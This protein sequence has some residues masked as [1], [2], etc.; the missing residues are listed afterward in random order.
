VYNPPGHMVATANQRP[1]GPSYPYYLG[2]TADFFDPGYRAGQIYALLHGRPRMSPAAFAAIQLNVT[3]ALARRIVPRLLAAL[4]GQYLSATQ[5]AAAGLLRGWDGSMTA[6]SGAAALW[7]TFWGDY[8]GAV[9]GPRWRAG[10][11]PPAHPPVPLDHPGA[12][13]RL[14]A[15]RLRWRRVDHRRRRRRA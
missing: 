8:L 7:W 12:G 11:G 10:L 13:T 6:S 3:D 15:A 2:T 14:R 4:H 1:V 5:H 9:F